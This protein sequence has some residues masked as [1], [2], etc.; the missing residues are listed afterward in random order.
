MLFIDVVTCTH[1]NDFDD[2]RRR[3]ERFVA[4]VWFLTSLDKSHRIQT[5]VPTN[6]DPIHFQPV[7]ERLVSF[8]N[9]QQF[10]TSKS[11]DEMQKEN[12][13]DMNNARDTIMFVK[14]AIATA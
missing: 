8:E 5:T 14:I 11:Y 12:P 4:R 6:G 10:I 13:P 2:F 3:S 1:A 9:A 7:L